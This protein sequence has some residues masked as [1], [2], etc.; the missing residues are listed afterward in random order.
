MKRLS[1]ALIVITILVVAWYSPKRDSARWEGVEDTRLFSEVG[2]DFGPYTSL[3][4]CEWIESRGNDGDSFRVRHGGE[5]TEFRLYYV[6]APESKYKEYANGETNGKRLDDQGRY[7][8]GLSREQTCALGQSA[9]GFVRELLSEG[10]FR[11]VTR[12]ENVYG[13]QRKYAFVVVEYEGGSY[14]LHEILVAKGLARIHTK[15]SVMPDGSSTG[16]Q[17]E[18]LSEMEGRAQESGRG[19]WGVISH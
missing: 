1:T 2:D 16:E 12:W 11:V 10:S 5:V 4:S 18:R 15:P 14:Y 17:L 13:P 8:G 6:D 7:F 19:G 9:K 3:E